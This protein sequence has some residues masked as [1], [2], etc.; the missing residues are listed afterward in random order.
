ML[1]VMLSFVWAVATAQT[2]TVRAPQQVAVGEQ[3]RL[4]YTANTQDVSGFRVGQ[5]P[6]AFEVLMGPSTSTQSSVQIVNG[7]TT[8]SSSVT[9]TYILSATSHGTFTIPPAHINAG[10]KQVSSSAAK[11]VVSGQAHS[12]QGGGRNQGQRQP[13]RPRAAGSAIT[14]EDLFIK[15]IASKRRVVEQE[16][17][18]LTYKVYSLVDLTQLEGKMPDLKGFHTQ[19]VELPQQKSFKVE[20]YNG[21][22]YRTV[23]WSQYVMFPQMSGKLQVPPITF[24]GIVMQQD[25]SI[26]PFEAFFNGGSNYIEVKKELKAP[27]VEIQ[28][29]PLPQ[30]PSGF[31]GG[32]GTF[33]IKAAIDKQQVKANDPVK[34]SVTI[35]GKGNLKLIK[36]PIVSFPKDFD[37]YDP[38]S[39]DKT[40]LT[41]AGVEGSI[42]YDYLAV[43]RHQGEYDIPPVEFT[44]YDT[45]S[46]QY[47]TIKTEPFHLIVEKGLGSGTTV[48]HFGTKEDVQMLAKDIRHIKL[49]DYKQQEGGQLF[50]ASKAYWT[51]LILMLIAFISLFLLFRRRAIENADVVK[52]KGRKADKVA[53]KRLKKARKLM[54]AQQASSFYDEVLRALWGYVSDKLNIS[55]EQLSRENIAAQ[56]SGREVGEDTVGRFISAI[57]ECEYARYAPG[58]A[59]GNMSKVYDKAM[60]AIGEIEDSMKRRKTTTPHPAARLLLIALLTMAQAVALAATKEEADSAYTSGHYQQAVQ[61]YEEMLQKGPSAELYYNLGNAYYRQDHITRAI[62]SYER[63][64]LLTPGDADIKFNLQMAQ[65]KTADKVVP[66]SEMFFVTWYHALVNMASADAWART[67]LAALALAIVLALLYLFAGAV[68]LRKMGFFGAA[69]ML[70]VFLLANGF[71][72]QQKHAIEHRTGAIIVEGAV[73]VKSTPADNGTDLFILHE[74]TKVSVSDATM[75][76]WREITVPDGKRGWVKTHQIEMI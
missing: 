18:L 75:S 41:T 39:T 64:L 12:Q 3:F 62:I 37:S 72:W 54:E 52:S 38:K 55:V 34:V 31:S 71:A 73:P 76:Q 57:D 69:A 7:R 25:R 45:S 56:L 29:D 8:V 40:R 51:L 22:P 60:T 27:G 15:V 43:P 21:R 9:Y 23:T 19:E 42:V 26:D 35:S 70:L 36:Q 30:R 24:S 65:S 2:L 61:L 6:D 10:G 17:V 58:D 11:I 33:S 32:V 59:Q 46:R 5:I 66:E 48:Q 47:R 68:A 4:Q 20:Q 14:A 1:L 44:Y 63:A 53:A 16:P 28:V 67:A 74:G 49:G 13:G 50:F